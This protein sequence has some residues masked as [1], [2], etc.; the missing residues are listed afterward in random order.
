MW[1][2]LAQKNNISIYRREP[3]GSSSRIILVTPDDKRIKI[4]SGRAY[5]FR[6]N[7]L[8]ALLFHFIKKRYKIS[9]KQNFASTQDI[10]N[11]QSDYNFLVIVG[12]TSYM[13]FNPGSRIGVVLLTNCDDASPI[14]LQANMLLNRLIN[15]I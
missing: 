2:L 8:D 6:N 11:I 5:L 13:V 15:H 10:Y 1:L 14:E 7:D 9:V 3:D 12:F 4:L